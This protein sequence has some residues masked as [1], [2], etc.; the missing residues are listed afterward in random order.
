MLRAHILPASERLEDGPPWKLVGPVAEHR[1]VGD[2]ARGRAAGPD[3][4]E[5]ATRPRGAKPIEVGRDCSLEPA[6]ASERIVRAVGEPVQQE[7]DDR[8][9]ESARLLVHT[10]RGVTYTS[11]GTSRFPQ[12]PSTGPLRGQA[13]SRPDARQTASR[14][15]DR[16]TRA[17]PGGTSDSQSPP[18]RSAA[19]TSAPEISLSAPSSRT[20]TS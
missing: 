13:A 17:T 16:I 11:G 20:T 5:D 8:M 12:A 19:R 3:R 4:I 1:P 15:R 14:C 6:P 9:H 18:L 2:L 7:D 10:T